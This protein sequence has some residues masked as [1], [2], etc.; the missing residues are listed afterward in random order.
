MS[1]SI[2]PVD[3]GNPVRFYGILIAIS[4][5]G[6]LAMNIF[7]PSIPGL[8]HEFSVSSGTVQLTLTIYL[9]GLAVSQLFYGPLSDRFGRRPVLLWG[10]ALYVV[11]SG[12]CSLAT[13]IEALT[14]ARFVQAIG[15]AS[16]MVLS[17]AIVRDLHGREAAASV[18]GYITMA[19]VLVPMFAPAL[20]GLLDEIDSWRTSFYVLSGFGTCVLLLVAWGLPETNPRDGRDLSEA[21]RLLSGMAALIKEPVFIAYTLTLGFCS[22]IFFSFLAGAPFLMVEVMGYSPL[23][24]GLWFMLISV[25]YMTGNFLSGRYSQRIGI[26]RMITIGNGLALVGAIA[27]LLVG[28]L[29]TLTPLTLFGFMLFVTLGNGLTVPN[30][31]AAAISVLPR[32]VGAA[33]GLSGFSQIG[34]GAAAS[35]LTGT[36]QGSFAITTLWVMIAGAILAGLVH[37]FMLRSVR[38]RPREF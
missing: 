16:G 14:V 34:I 24:Y 21:N 11:S 28:T 32:T 12:I 4:T 22:A 10:L 6:P 25:G 37:H 15:G 30:G 35:Q 1:Q 9:A 29:G 26:D 31:M 17:R 33:A 18:L 19:W 8:M 27:M 36:L 20:G 38:G 2:A 5:I 13:S 3:V 7:V 23:D